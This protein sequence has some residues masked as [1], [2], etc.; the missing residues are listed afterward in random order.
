MRNTL[1]MGDHYIILPNYHWWDFSEFKILLK[2]G[3]P[4]E[5]LKEYS[6]GNNSDWLS[7]DQLHFLI[8]L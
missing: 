7:K 4:V 5:G 8:I 2:T 1:D 3:K 6:S